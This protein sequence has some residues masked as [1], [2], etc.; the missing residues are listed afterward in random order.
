MTKPDRV[1]PLELDHDL[2]HQGREWL[3]S[4]VLWVVLLA[5]MGATAL[6]VF[7]GGVVSRAHAASPDNGL[8]IEYERFCRF[9]APFRLTVHARP[10]AGDR[11]VRIS[12]SAGYL[13][14]MRV[15]TVTPLPESVHGS[16]DGVQ[17]VFSAERGGPSTIH[18][19]MQPVRRWRVHGSVRGEDAGLPVNHFVYP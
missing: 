4:R 10:G 9:G 15:M 2:A 3:A 12:L 16:D 5:I 6:G 13:E 18:F 14:A 11:V 17:Y 1:G 7:G 8:R 19:T